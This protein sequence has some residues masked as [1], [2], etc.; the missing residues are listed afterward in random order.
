MCLQQM[1]SS[2]Q[3]H[4][5]TAATATSAAIHAN[6]CGAHDQKRFCV[7]IKLV[8]SHL[9]HRWLCLVHTAGLECCKL[10]GWAKKWMSLLPDMLPLCKSLPVE[11]QQQQQQQHDLMLLQ[12]SQQR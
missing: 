9:T 12:Q 6:V 7:V 3:E 11:Q 10:L 5:P 4:Q 2:E 1:L 8:V